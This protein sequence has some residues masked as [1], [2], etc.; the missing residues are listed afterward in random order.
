MLDP[1]RDFVMDSADDGL[2]PWDREDGEDEPTCF[3]T[4]RA[5]EPT[6]SRKA[7]LP[8]LLSSEG[9]HGR[10]LLHRACV[11]TPLER[12]ARKHG[13]VPVGSV[14]EAACS[15][16]SSSVWS[17]LRGAGTQCSSSGSP[18]ESAESSTGCHEGAC[19]RVR[20]KIPYPT[21]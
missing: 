3:D 9:Q 17:S 11:L 15:S 20:L 21:V 18:T 2:D 1:L 6:A 14:A 10:S 7:R 8:I 19:K 16:P 4:V 12:D 5:A 13:G